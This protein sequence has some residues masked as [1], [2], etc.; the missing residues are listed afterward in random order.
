MTDKSVEVISDTQAEE[1]ERIRQ[2]IANPHAF[3]VLYEKYF[4]KIYLFVL[5]RVNDKDLVADLTQQV[6][7][8]ALSNL[9]RYEFRGYSFSAWLCRIAIN[10]CNEFY[11]KTKRSRVVVLEDK[12]VGH[13]IEELTADQTM[14]EWE[15][16][17]PAILEKLDQ[18]ELHVIELR[19]FE[20][21]PFKEI[22]GILGITENN[23]KG[24]TYRILDKMKKLFLNKK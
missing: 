7:L 22:A 14:E 17:L 9:G 8:N 12:M 5:H 4:K 21:R 10:Q 2:A 24:R 13:L 11:R 16:Q 19:F 15:K 23:A 6:F 3:R 20:G 18:D 1:D